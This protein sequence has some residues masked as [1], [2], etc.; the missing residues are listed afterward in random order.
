MR[1]TSGGDLNLKEGGNFYSGQ[2]RND[3]V[4]V[5]ATSTTVLDFTGEVAGIYIITV[6]RSGSSVGENLVCIVAWD[7]SGGNVLTTLTNAGFISPVFVGTS[8]RV[9]NGNNRNCH[10]TAQ[11]LSLS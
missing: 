10:A 11:P 5:P 7:G 1:I 9:S 8:F 3:L 4:N 2:L 6:C